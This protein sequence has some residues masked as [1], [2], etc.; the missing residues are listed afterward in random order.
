MSYALSIFLAAALRQV[1][2]ANW[3]HYRRLKATNPGLFAAIELAFFLLV[4]APIIFVILIAALDG[5]FPEQSRVAGEWLQQH[6]Q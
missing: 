5:L 1:V 6:R 4:I 2:Y 3:H